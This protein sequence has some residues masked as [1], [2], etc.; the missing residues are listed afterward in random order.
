MH[1]PDGRAALLDVEPDL[2]P[3]GAVRERPRGHRPG[4]PPGDVAL[5]VVQVER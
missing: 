4:A 1:L 5:V 3:G 2:M